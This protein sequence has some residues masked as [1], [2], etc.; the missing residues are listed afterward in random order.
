MAMSARRLSIYLQLGALTV[1]AMLLP[2]SG[3]TDYRASI[4][5][6]RDKQEAELTSDDGWLTVAGLFW[7][8]EGANSFGA[9]L[10]NDI[11][12]PAGSAPGK[13]GAFEFHNGN[14]TL[15]VENG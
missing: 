14:T 10:S 15:H 11:V 6:W 1:S 4:Q 2:V 13:A 5:K 3:Q 9:D 12:L 7:L 8:K